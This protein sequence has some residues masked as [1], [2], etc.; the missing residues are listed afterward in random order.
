V[1]A[2]SECVLL[3][4]VSGIFLPP[5]ARLAALLPLRSYQVPA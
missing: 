5:Q 4:T 2:S 3:C 1:N